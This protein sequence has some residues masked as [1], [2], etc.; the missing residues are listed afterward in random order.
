MI[1]SYMGALCL[2]HCFDEDPVQCEVMISYSILNVT[3]S[4]GFNVR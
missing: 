3:L 1:K 2:L 4:S